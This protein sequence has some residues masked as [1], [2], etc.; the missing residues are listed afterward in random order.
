MIKTYV[1]G[2]WLNK[3]LYNDG[4]SA[5]LNRCELVKQIERVNHSD[6]DSDSNSECDE[7]DNDYIE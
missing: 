6:N 1:G 3:I 4:D 7:N 2:E 5:E